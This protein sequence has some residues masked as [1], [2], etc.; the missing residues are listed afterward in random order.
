MDNAL[1]DPIAMRSDRRVLSGDARMKH[2]MI[3]FCGGAA[4]GLATLI[5]PASAMPAAPLNQLVLPQGEVSTETVAWR[6]VC[7]QVRVWSNGRYRWV[8]Q[9]NRVW[10]GPGR[11]GYGPG[12]GPG[13]GMYGAPPPRYGYPY[14]PPRPY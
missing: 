4:L 11:Y 9:C 2:L 12:P 13:R 6:R 3:A 1:S 7:R 5:S 14:G 10:V 8:R